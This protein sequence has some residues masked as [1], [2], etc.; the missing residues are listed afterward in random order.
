MGKIGSIII[1]GLTGLDQIKRDKF[2]RKL[3]GRTV[4][5]HKGKYTHHIEGILDTIPHLRVARGILI[6]DRAYKQ[7]L[8]DFF[9]N[10]GVRDIFIRDL[11]LTKSDIHKLKDER[12]NDTL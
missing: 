10:H 8:S 3:L 11:I 2:C 5:T 12:Q 1:Y 4:K 9:R 7:T 6:V